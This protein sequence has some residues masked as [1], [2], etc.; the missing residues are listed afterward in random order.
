MHDILGIEMG[1]KPW[2]MLDETYS[3]LPRLML[4]VTYKGSLLRAC[5]V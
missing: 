4:V 5:A 2:L 3:R 1:P